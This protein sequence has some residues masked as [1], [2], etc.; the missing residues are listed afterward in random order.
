M[1]Y[2]RQPGPRFSDDIMRIKNKVTLF[3]IIIE[4]NRHTKVKPIVNEV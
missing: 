1:K 2:P 4:N 3:W